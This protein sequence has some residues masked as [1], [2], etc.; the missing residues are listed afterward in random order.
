M[1]CMCNGVHVCVCDLFCSSV[2]GNQCDMVWNCSSQDCDFLLLS[3]LGA[4]LKERW[5]DYLDSLLTDP[6]KKT[7]GRISWKNTG[8]AFA[9]RWDKIGKVSI[10]KRG[11][12]FLRLRVIGRYDRQKHGNHVLFTLKNILITEFKAKMYTWIK[13]QSSFRLKFTSSKV[14]KNTYF[15]QCST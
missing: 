4:W 12:D 3:I 1:V 6:L 7:A 14:L 2:S 8:E 9:Q 15:V 13:D 5:R 11:C 10:K